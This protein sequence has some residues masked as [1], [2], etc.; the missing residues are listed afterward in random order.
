VFDPSR[1]VISAFIDQLLAA[2]QE[3]FGDAEPH[4]PGLISRAAHMAMENI[5]NTDALY[6]NVE[7]TIMVTLVG[8][9]MLKG[10]HLREGSVTPRDWL[11]TV[12]S[13]LCHDIGYI[14]GVLPGDRRGEYVIDFKGRTVSVPPGATDA[15]LTPHH[16]TRGQIFIHQRFRDHA[17]IDPKVVAENIEYTRFPVPADAAAGYKGYPGLVGAADLVGQMADPHYIR[18]LPALFHEFAETG[19]AA[20][21]GYTTPDDL[22]AGYPKFYWSMVS[23]FVGDGLGHLSVTQQGRQWIASLYAQIFAEEERPDRAEDPAPA[24]A[25]AQVA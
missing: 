1:L 9:E 20:H 25:P 13:L 24:H 22:R 5:A 11:H 10:K 3:T 18:K 15:F 21:M 23:A 19:A 4:F 8:Q 2:Y 16:V 7:H 6:H 17:Y 14:R 12:V